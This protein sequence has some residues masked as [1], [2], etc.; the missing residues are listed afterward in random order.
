MWKR[1]TG[2]EGGPKAH[3]SSEEGLDGVDTGW[4]KTRSEGILN[5]R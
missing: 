3:Q 2:G 4:I 1:L 5:V